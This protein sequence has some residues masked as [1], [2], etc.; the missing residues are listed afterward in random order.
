MDSRLPALAEQLLLIERELRLAGLWS[1]VAPSAEALAS[2]QP[3]CV[4]SLAF[5]EW[6][7]WIL[8]PRMKTLLEEDLPLPNGSG[9]TAMAEVAFAGRSEQLPELLAA[10]NRFDQLLGAR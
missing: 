3:F 5:E 2:E 9:I 10:L 4:D 7:Q 8:L 1:A 6:L